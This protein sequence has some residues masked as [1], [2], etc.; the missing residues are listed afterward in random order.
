MN[1]IHRHVLGAL[2]LAGAA[3]S[4]ATLAQTAAP[5]PATNAP[6]PAAATPTAPPAGTTSQSPMQNQN[7]NQTQA[8]PQAAQSIPAGTPLTV[9]TI[10]PVTTKLP[11]GTK[12]AATLESPIPGAQGQP[13]LPVG[14]RVFGRVK[15]SSGGG[16]VRKPRLVVELAEIQTPARVVPIV[17][18]TAGAEGGHGGA[19]KK[20]GAGTLI[21]AAAGN[22]GA[23][24]AVGGAVVLLQGGKDLSIPPGTLMEFKLT[25]PAQLK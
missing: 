22:A 2:V 8:P 24:A 16:A 23:G 17:T 14:T 15:E 4:G 7:Q 1:R 6:P 25:Q 3:Y 19:L 20:V 12:F 11:A 10:D 21:G 5:P 18:D 9:R 13:M